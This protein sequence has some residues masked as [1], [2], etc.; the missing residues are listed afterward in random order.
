M[1]QSISC[2]LAWM[3]GFV[4]IFHFVP[5]KLKKKKVCKA[6]SEK[7]FLVPFHLTGKDSDLW[8]IANSAGQLPCYKS[9]VLPTKTSHGAHCSLL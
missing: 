4:F 1:G 6:L 5:L 8:E 2:S 7:Y 3:G 9:W